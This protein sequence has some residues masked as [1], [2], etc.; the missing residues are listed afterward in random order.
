[1]NAPTAID[2]NHQTW[3]AMGRAARAAAADLRNADEAAKNSALRFAADALRADAATIL[4]AN[5]TDLENA[6]AHNLSDAMTDRLALDAARLEAIAVSLNDIAALPDPVGA[7]IRSTTRP[8]GLVIERVRT[9][10]G[11]VGVIYES[12]PNVT[13]DASALC[14]KS[15]NAAILRGGSEAIATSKALHAC[16]VQGLKEARL[17][18]TA[19][20]LVETTDR[21]AVGA[22]LSGL[23]GAVDLVIPRGG[24]SLVARVQAEAKTPVLSHLDGVCHVYL[25]ED[26]DLDKAVAI[27]VNAKMRRTGVCGAAET[28]LIDRAALARFLPPVADALRAAGCRLIGDDAARAVDA[29]IDAATEKDFATEFLGPTLSIA[30]VDGVDGAAAHIARYGSGHTETII[31]ENDAAATAFLAAVD[32]AIVMHNASTQ[33]ADGGEFGL[34]AEIGIATGKLHARGPV[35][36]EELTTYKNIVRG[37]D[38]CRP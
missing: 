13:I 33:F 20:Q 5:E 32:S 14:L 26:A 2:N 7:I 6:R 28:L 38:H 25:H 19:S 31:T 18:E 17:P 27:T 37:A 15:G 24:K 35:G 10:I 23:D 4:A 21:A 3:L 30:A 11:V 9:P 1:M 22:L 16:F 12:R 8:N 29:A 34:G 36:L